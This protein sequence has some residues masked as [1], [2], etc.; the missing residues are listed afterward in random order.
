MKKSWFLRFLTILTIFWCQK[1]EHKNFMFFHE[2]IVIFVKIAIF[3][4]FWRFFEF[5][6]G[7][8]GPSGLARGSKRAKKGLGRDHVEVVQMGNKGGKGRPEVLWRWPGG[9]QNWSKSSFWPFLA[10]NIG[11][12]TI[13][14][15]SKRGQKWPKLRLKRG[16]KSMLFSSKNGHFWGFFGH[17]WPFSAKKGPGLEAI[18]SPIEALVERWSGGKNG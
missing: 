7:L 11:F 6:E 8:T 10:W 17:F 18:S 3:S 13:F 4:I 2:K 12:L 15:G 1:I 14:E 9:G 5:F 16:V